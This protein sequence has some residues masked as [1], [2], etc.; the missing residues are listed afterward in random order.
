MAPASPTLPAATARREVP[1]VGREVELAVLDDW[2]QQARTGRRQV[3]FVAAPVGVGKTALID[4]FVD[5]LR[6]GEHVL[7]GRG[8]CVA[9]FGESEAYLPVLDAL[10]GLCRGSH[11][12]HVREILGTAAPTWLLQLPR[13]LEPADLEALRLRTVGATAERMLRELGDAVE[14]LTADW[15]LVLV[16][17]GL[18]RSDRA[19]IEV[20][21]YL[22][23][24]PAPARLL[25]VGTYRSPEVLSDSHPLRQVVRE[26]RAQGQCSFLSLELLG[27]PAVAA[28]LHERLAPGRPSDALIADVHQHTDGNALFMTTVVNYLI[29]RG[30]LTD[31]GGEIRSQEPLDRLGIPDSVGQF[32]EQQLHELAVPDRELLEIAAVVGVEFSAA[33]V[34]AGAGDERPGLRAKEVADLCSTLAWDTGLLI[35]RDLAE[36]PDGTVTAQYRFHHALYQEVL[37]GSLSPGRRE[38]VHRRIGT[39]LAA[40]FGSRSGEIAAELA[41]HFERGQVFSQAIPYL[42]SAAEISLQRA[43]HRETLDYAS[44]GLQLLERA[45]VIDDRPA[46]ELRLRMMQT[47]ALVTLHGAG[48]PGVDQ[49]Y[50][51]ARAVSAEIDDATL[52]GPVL[53]GLWNFAFNR[54]RMSDAADLSEELHGLARRNPDPVLEMQAHGTTGYTHVLAGRPA[55]ALP[56]LEQGLALYDPTAHRRLALVYGED[57]GVGCHQWAAYATWLLGYPDRARRHATEACRLAQNLGYPN[58]IAQ[59]TWFATVVHILCRDVYRARQLSDSLLGVCQKYELTRWSALGQLVDAWMAAQ[60]GEPHAAI[61][62][63]RASLADYSGASGFPYF[64]SSLL[65]EALA[66]AGDTAGAL[67][68]ASGALV[69][70]RRTGQLWYAA[71]LARLRG[72]ILLRSAPSPAIGPDDLATDAEHA[73]VEALE[74]A[75]RQQARS[76][77]LRAATSLA[78]LWQSQAQHQRARDVLAGTYRWFTEGHD[79]GDLQAA[80][81]VLAELG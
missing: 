69:M 49:A 33:A 21:A 4:V 77:E 50:L 35:E 51:H 47:V 63:M 30:Q 45:G 1:F 54:G 61:P 43:A 5:R 71:E 60:K 53:Y 25:I 11:G 14:V 48:S 72:E 9:Q 7:V 10:S 68:T 38:V 80:A 39:R 16:C 44:R 3:V 56:H 6:D 19:T 17:E 74:I 29:D 67:E 20:L 73:L 79:T 57:P 40:G 36:W 12:H 13:L 76:L 46:L 42:A 78:R 26:L 28:Y 55:T 64:S 52:L 81:A 66:K 15:P 18:H 24:R 8:L 27:R 31:V 70:A 75:R 32:I 23:G 22:A 62:Q 41:M 58:D 34:L 59:A 65:A 2:W 37:Y